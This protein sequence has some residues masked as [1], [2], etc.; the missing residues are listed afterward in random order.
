MVTIDS[1]PTI[2]FRWNIDTD[3]WEY[4]P[5]RMYPYTTVPLEP[6][7]IM[8]RIPIDDSLKI[9]HHPYL[10]NLENPALA[11]RMEKSFKKLVDMLSILP[12]PACAEK[13]KKA[14]KKNS[15]KYEYISTKSFK[16][17]PKQS[18][19][20]VKHDRK[21]RTKKGIDTET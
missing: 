15:E 12:P 16:Y 6:I 20:L 3:C 2:K 14:L 9:P 10:N 5:T 21:S 11:I 7:E 17:L 8:V 19:K 4:C 1:E 18:Q 13:L